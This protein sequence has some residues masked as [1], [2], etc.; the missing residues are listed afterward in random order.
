M[1]IRRM[2]VSKETAIVWG[3]R[4]CQNDCRVSA[5]V[6]ATIHL[7]MVA[8][9]VN[10]HAMP[11]TVNVTGRKGLVNTRLDSISPIVTDSS[12]SE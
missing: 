8:L 4:A 6:S 5:R 11:L 2:Q 3:H 12:E 7:G 9:N 1:S 10:G